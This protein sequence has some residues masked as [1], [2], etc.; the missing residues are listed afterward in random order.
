[1]ETI[2]HI[3]IKKLRPNAVVPARA[4]SGSAGYDLSACLDSELTLLP[5]QPVII[6]TGI[7]I[8]L[9][10]TTPCAAFIYGRS[11]L[12]VKHG[13]I[14]SNGV[15]VVD[16]D[17]RGEIMVGLT[18]ISSTPY[19]LQPGE[20][21][22]QLVIQPVLLPLPMETDELSETSRGAGGFGS[23]GRLSLHPDTNL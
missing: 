11:G 20:R 18:N 21:I 6:P 9:T 1:M 13:L 7:A 19:T 10:Y 15:G 8:E 16:S 14:L 23:T 12:G 2:H 22:A 3:K 4:T 5:G 17:Y